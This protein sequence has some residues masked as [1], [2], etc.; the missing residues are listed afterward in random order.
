MIASWWDAHHSL[1]DELWGPG[2]DSQRGRGGGGGGVSPSD[3][4]LGAAYLGLYGVLRRTAVRAHIKLSSAVVG[5]L[6]P[7]ATVEVLEAR[8][9]MPPVAAGRSGRGAKRAGGA[10][11]QRNSSGPRVHVRLRSRYGKSSMAI[12]GWA[13]LVTADGHTLLQKL[14]ED[15]GQGAEAAAVT[16]KKKKKKKK[17]KRKKSSLASAG[18]EAAVAAI[19]A[20]QRPTLGDR[21]EHLRLGSPSRAAR[22]ERALITA[23]AASS[24]GL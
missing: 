3:Q 16:V 1:T 18:A 12:C 14:A 22:R 13:C 6:N 5:S 4:A 20:E 7:G 21:D 9:L 11:Q 15:L 10:E 17:K 23:A 24:A 19:A 2:A 8:V